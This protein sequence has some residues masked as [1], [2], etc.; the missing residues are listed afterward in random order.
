MTVSAN[1]IQGNLAG[2]GD[3]GGI[4]AEFVNG[5]DVLRSPNNASPWYQLTLVNNMV[6]NNVA[7]LAGG[8]ISLQDAVRANISQQ[9]HRQQ[10]Q[11]GDGGGGIRSRQPE[12]VHCAA[13]RHR[14]ARP[15]HAAVQHDRQWFGRGAYKREFSNP[16]L[17]N[18]IVWHNRSFFWEITTPTSFE[19]LPRVASP[20]WDLAVVGTSNPA[21]QLSPRYSLLTD[22]TGYGGANNITGD[23]DFVAWTFNGDR[24]QTIQMP[25]LTT[26]IATAAALDEG[27]NWI[28]VRFG[29]LTLWDCSLPGCPLFRDYHLQN[30]SPAEA[31]GTL[32]TG[33]PL[34]DF[35]GQ[36]RP[37]P[38]FPLRPDIGADERN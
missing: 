13:G 16:T 5:L 3:G 20:Y 4:R 25:E 11:H 8:G 38:M 26:S 32:A 24:G 28:D 22:L 18:N 31:A 21:D 12:P 17:L 1:L 30:G 10:R 19:L 23:P 33:V 7:G 27:G 6:V 14:V 15:Q 2:A 35:D 34:V 29:P 36:S 37:I 9:H